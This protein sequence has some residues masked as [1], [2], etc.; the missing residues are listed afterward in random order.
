MTELAVKQMWAGMAMM[1]MLSQKDREGSYEDIASDAWQM[2]L[3]MEHE[4]TNLEME[5]RD[6]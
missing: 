2:A 3:S 1:A 4:Q 6:V 5:A